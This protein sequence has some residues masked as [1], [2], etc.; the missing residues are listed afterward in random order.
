MASFRYAPGYQVVGRYR[1]LSTIG[2][3]GTSEVYLAEDLALDRRVALKTLRPDLAEHED[4]R[5]AFRTQII[6]AATLSHPHIARVFD[7]GQE[8]GTIFMVT[9]YLGNG[10]LEDRLGAGE[11][12]GV[13]DAA[14]LGRD[15]AGALAAMHAHGVTHG[16]LSPRKI[17][18]DEL[19][20]VRVSD[21][22][23][24]GLRAMHRQRYTVHDLRYLSPEQVRGELPGP[25][26]DVYALALILAEAVTGAAPFDASTAE[27]SAQARLASPLPPH[28]ELGTLDMVLAQ[29]TVPDPLQRL[30]AETMTSRLGAATL[31]ESPVE[32]VARRGAMPVLQQ[33]PPLAPRASIG[34]R[35]PSPRELA[36]READPDQE[37][38]GAGD[39][40]KTWMPSRHRA[41][42]PYPVVPPPHRHRTATAVAAVVILAVVAAVAWW[43]GLFSAHQAI[44]RLEG[45]TVAQATSQLTADG[46]SVSVTRHVASGSVA[47]GAI[48]SQSPAAGVSAGSGQVISVTVSSGPTVVTLPSVTGQSCTAAQVALGRVGVH[49]ACPASAAVVSTLPAGQVVEARYH[50]VTDPSSVARGATITLVLSSGPSGAA[51]TN[52]STTTTTAPAAT[53]TTVAPTTATVAGQGPR[54]VP[55]VIGLGP[56]ATVAAFRHAVLFFSPK[57]P[58][59][60]TGAWT[61]VVSTLPSPGTMVPY[62]STII[63]NV[64]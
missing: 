39:V 55:N 28:P 54:P 6:R 11:L 21:V 7:G 29:A 18:V 43:F 31:D 59:A 56:T 25:A 16:G 14:R 47:R 36:G 30:D 20:H 1:I 61:K 44:P 8:S 2:V 33:V 10:S 37:F 53:S 40:P 52:P 17:L 62:R 4:V 27:A 57:G 32:L 42:D 45:L 35:A 12:L 3:G 34:F 46:F 24:V 60:T 9:E 19:G 50:G 58:G 22:A 48:I 41:S 26:T 15:V 5:R 13:E 38:A 64:R 23:L 49:G 51:P 63:V